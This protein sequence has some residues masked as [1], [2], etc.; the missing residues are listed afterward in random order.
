MSSDVDEGTFRDH[1][2]A[3]FP[4]VLQLKLLIRETVMLVLNVLML[5]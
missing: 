5:P 3:T 2:A 1:F 4:F